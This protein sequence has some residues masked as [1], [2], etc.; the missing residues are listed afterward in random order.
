MNLCFFSGNII[1]NPI[2][3]FI[4]SKEKSFKQCNHISICMFELKLANE[5]IIK[6][7]AYDELADFCYRN[8]RKGNFI[9]VARNIK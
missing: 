9:V 2:F 4:I 6:V 5:T 1:T 7:K 3:K 8:L